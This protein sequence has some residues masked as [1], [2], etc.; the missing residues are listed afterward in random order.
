MLI[1]LEK[2]NMISMLI[3]YL[4][5]FGVALILLLAI[6]KEILDLL[7]YFLETQNM[8][9]GEKGDV[10]GKKEKKYKVVGA[11]KAERRTDISGSHEEYETKE[12]GS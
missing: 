3:L 12:E 10:K 8:M 1:E 5:L 9:K 11:D 4:I 7:R 6:S 2:A